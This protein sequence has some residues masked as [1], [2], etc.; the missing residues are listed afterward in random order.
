VRQLSAFTSWVGAGGRA[1]TSAG[2]LRPADARELVELLGTGEED[3]KVRSSTELPQLNLIFTWAKKAGLVRA[4]K[5]RLVQVAGATRLLGDT[6]VLWQ[7][8]FDAFSELRDVV[9]LPIW[10]PGDELSMLYEVYAQAV[11]DVLNTIYSLPHPMPLAR[12]EESVW[13]TCRQRFAVDAGSFLQQVAARERVGNDLVHVFEVLA[14][15]GAAEVTH[16]LA[17]EMFTADLADDYVMPIPVER[18]ISGATAARLRAELARPGNLVALTALGTRAMRR[19]LLAEGR[20]AGLVGDLADAEPAELLGV[21]AEHYTAETSKAEID[22]WLAGRG[23]DIAPLLDAVRACPFRARAAAM[24]DVLRVAIPGWTELLQR[25]RDDQVLAPLAVEALVNEGAL[26]E[27]DLTEREDA[28]LMTEGL[29]Q[30]LELDGP[31]AVREH[32]DEMF[33]VDLKDLLGEMLSC[34]HPGTWTL[35]DFQALVP[36]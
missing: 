24:L 10:G 14:A 23:G 1:L 36:D 26:D 29:L 32:L 33:D 21:L 19:R 3:L 31:D 28:L 4:G 34:G 11:P 12:L 5:T 16:G 9:C 13:R 35:E 15:L 25:L 2:N 20:E 7:R 17:D 6:E 22:G 8:A 27:D 18:P 30:L